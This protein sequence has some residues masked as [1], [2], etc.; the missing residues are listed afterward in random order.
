MYVKPELRFFLFSWF[1]AFQVLSLFS[2]STT[3]GCV[4]LPSSTTSSYWEILIVVTFETTEHLQILMIEQSFYS[5]KVWFNQL[6][7][8]IKN[9]FCHDQ[10]AKG[11]YQPIIIYNI[12]CGV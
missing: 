5:Q 1:M 11:Y 12:A 4:S 10:Q 7:K 6:I 2:F 9:D 3:W 8:R